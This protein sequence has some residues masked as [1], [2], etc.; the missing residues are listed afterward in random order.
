VTSSG[1]LIVNEFLVSLEG[2]VVILSRIR[3]YLGSNVIQG[4]MPTVVKKFAH[5]E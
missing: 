2:Q 1:R 4:E 3:E 5:D